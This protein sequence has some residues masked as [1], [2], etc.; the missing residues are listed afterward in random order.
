MAPLSLAAAETV[1]S[2]VVE[3]LVR[4]TTAFVVQPAG[5]V[6]TCTCTRVTVTA[7]S[8][9]Q[10]CAVQADVNAPGRN[11]VN[12]PRGLAVSGSP[13]KSNRYVEMPLLERMLEPADVTGG[14]EVPQVKLKVSTHCAVAAG[15]ALV[16]L[17][18]RPLMFPRAP[19]RY[20]YQPMVPVGKAGAVTVTV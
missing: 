9:V 3:P 17:P 7:L 15:I 1:T 5:A 6:F 16:Q 19:L 4:R 12:G 18:V 10:V 11:A 13:F 20:G 8:N 14:C 2:C